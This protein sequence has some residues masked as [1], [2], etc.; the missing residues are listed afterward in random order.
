MVYTRYYYK[1]V[2]LLLFFLGILG[3]VRLCFDK[4]VTIMHSSYKLVKT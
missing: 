3:K 2:M 1:Y 4:Y